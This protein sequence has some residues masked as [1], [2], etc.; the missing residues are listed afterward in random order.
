MCAGTRDWPQLLSECMNALKPGGYVELIEM[1]ASPTSDDNSIPSPYQVGEFLRIVKHAALDMGFDLNVAVKFSGLLETAGFV[2]VTE[3]R[4]M[5]PLGPWALD[6]L[7]KELG[8][9]QRE[10]FLQGLDAIGMYYLTKVKGWTLE[11]VEVFFQRTKEDVMNDSIHCYWKTYVS[12]LL[13]Y[14]L[15]DTSYRYF[16]YGQKP[17]L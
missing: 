14:D 1:D 9:Y 12:C 4:L 16:V 13:D 3:E 8:L 5:L 10:Q 6:P 17:I 7:Q 11:E 2:G 15:T